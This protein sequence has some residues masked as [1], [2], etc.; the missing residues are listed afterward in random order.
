MA[1]KKQANPKRSKGKQHAFAY[2]KEK[3]ITKPL[4]GRKVGDTSKRSPFVNKRKIKDLSLH[5][6]LKER[7]EADQEKNDEYLA[8]VRNTY[9]EQVRAERERNAHTARQIRRRSVFRQSENNP[10][11]ANGT[12]VWPNLEARGFTTTLSTSTQPFDSLA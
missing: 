4:K 11:Q 9:P 3:P 2:K 8:I 5:P 7:F 1:R 6:T 10:E 12:Y